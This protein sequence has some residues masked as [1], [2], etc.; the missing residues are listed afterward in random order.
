MPMDED[1]RQLVARLQAA[2]AQLKGAPRLVPGATL[3][4][5][6]ERAG[7]PTGLNHPDLS[8]FPRPGVTELS[9]RAGSGRLRLLRP[10][11]AALTRRGARAAI[12]DP[13][14]RLYPPGLDEVV[15]EQLLVVQAS[16]EQTGWAAEQ[17]ARSGLFLLVVLLDPPRLGRGGA[18][19]SRAVEQ[20]DCA[21]VVV[22]EGSDS[23]LPA[24]LRLR[25]LGF[26]E[27][28]LRVELQRALGAAGGQKLEL[29]L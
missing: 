13:L 26:K 22:T 17:L 14:G 1:R 2:V 27:G 8:A 18:R 15:L 29:N 7:L 12:L 24:D 23:G 25:T 9:G 6:P 4:A 3:G 11:L 10:A 16:P 28:T 19:L 20:G 21:A 5:T